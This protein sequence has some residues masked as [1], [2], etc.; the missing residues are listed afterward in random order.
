MD[1]NSNSTI[2]SIRAS[3]SLDAQKV[4]EQM[5]TIANTYIVTDWDDEVTRRFDALLRTVVKRRSGAGDTSSQRREAR[6]IIYTG[7]EGVGKT[8]SLDRLF[9]THPAIPGYNIPGSGC[10]L[11][12]VSATASTSPIAL[13]HAILEKAGRPIR[14]VLREDAV[15][16]QVHHQLQLAGI[17]ILHLDEMHNLTD[18]A[19]AN[20]IDHIR[21][22]LKALMVSP[23]W[24]VA[25]IISGLPSIA[26]EM[27]VV[28]EIRRRGLFI[29]MPLME[30]PADADLVKA[31][32]EKT[33]KLADL[34]LPDDRSLLAGR[35]VH[36][37]IYR[38]GVMIELI[39]EAVE[40][41]LLEKAQQLKIEHFAGAYADRTGSGPRMNPFLAAD[42]LQLDCSLVLMSAPPS[43]I[44]PASSSRSDR[45]RKGSK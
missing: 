20:Q 17:A 38:F 8:E 14:K 1:N 24:P 40:L 35:L 25:L 11:L 41:A 31:A 30:M 13:G 33:C 18:N 4:S 32:V 28:G 22:R 29:Q 10:P 21:K 15:W 7:E 16:A 37:A 45:G 39:Q 9:R 2:D 3:M 23:T 26:P 12:S 36:A 44:L 27:R 34:A 42:W 5:E 43:Q 19:T 6:A